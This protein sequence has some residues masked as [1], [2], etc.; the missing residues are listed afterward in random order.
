[1]T[2]RTLAV[3]S[4][5]FASLVGVARAETAPPTLV[6]TGSGEAEV[7]PDQLE[8]SFAV[9]SQAEQTE[10]AMEDNAE[11]IRR[12]IRA[13]E[14]AGVEEDDIETVGFSVS[15]NYDYSNRRNGE[16][17]R[18]TG[19]T[20]QNTIRVRTLDLSKAGEL[21]EEGVK[22]GADRVSGVNF[23]LAD[24]QAHRAKAIAEATTNARRDAEAL[25][26][27]AGLELAGILEITLDPAHDYRPYA[28][29]QE[30]ATRAMSDAAPEIRPGEVSLTARVRVVYEVRSSR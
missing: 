30:M 21:I 15:P 22:A 3:L 18:I 9:V 20:V 10:D 12:V 14:R 6:V 7:E 28:A 27:A 1:M 8:V 13:L 24:P 17:P 23:G 26:E 5:F 11:R 19:Y 16:P 29:R 4:L 2:T 25:A